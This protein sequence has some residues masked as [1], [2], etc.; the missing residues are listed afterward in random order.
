MSVAD[1]VSTWLNALFMI[2]CLTIVFK[3]NRL[4]RF[5]EATLIGG[6]AGYFVIVALSLL[7]DNL[8]A[9]YKGEYWYILIYVIGAL[10]FTQYIRKY[11]WL[12]RIPVVVESS[13][14][15]ALAIVTAIGASVI[16]QVSATMLDPT[17]LDNVLI[18]VVTVC[19]MVFFLF[20]LQHKGPVGILARIG[21]YGIMVAFGIALGGEIS[22]RF[23]VLLTMIRYL[24]SQWLG[25]PAG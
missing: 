4:Y 8:G 16:A 7:R 3:E 10:F 18:V 15:L 24:L 2:G 23:T 11:R 5:V 17:S 6:T 1:T 12:S 19:A 22:K 25:I 21:Q 9:V 20:T 14:G 13:V